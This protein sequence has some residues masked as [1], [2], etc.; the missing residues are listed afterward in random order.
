MYT[1]GTQQISILGHNLLALT[2]VATLFAWSSTT[3]LH[4]EGGIPVK[5]EI[6][7][8]YDGGREGGASAT[9]IH[10][11][12]EMP[13][14]HLGFMLHYHDV[15]TPLPD[16]ADIDRYRG[17]LTW[18]AGPVLDV[19]AYLAWI[20]QVAGKGPRFVLLGDVGIAI[21]SRNLPFINRLFGA[22]GLRHTGEYVMATRGTRVVHKDAEL[23]EFE[24]QLDPVLAEYPIIEVVGAHVRLGLA[25][26]TPP[27]EGR[28]PTSVLT[29][30]EKGAY[31][32]FNY[33]F[34][35]Q[36]APTH[37][38]KWLL[39]PFTFFQLAFGAQRFPVPDTTTVSGRRLFFCQLHSER[40][41]NFS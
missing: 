19:D 2:L 21:T 11:F 28:L 1:F 3:A 22:L 23:I 8:L 12:A 16:P 30:N 27:H 32:A 15:R 7:A 36:R 33:E 37:R 10:R 24:C 29:V 25:L 5:R 6:L 40:W 35:H 26:E 13:L 39:D 4:A 41:S 9:R 34:C 17:I 31:A 38:G 18:F 20:G 14:N